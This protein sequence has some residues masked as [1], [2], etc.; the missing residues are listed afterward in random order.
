MIN[1]RYDPSRGMES[2]D[3]AWVS[4][5]NAI[6]RRGRAGRVKHGVCFHLFTS[7]RYHNHLIEQPIPGKNTNWYMYHCHSIFCVYLLTF[8]DDLSVE[9]FLLIWLKFLEKTYRVFTTVK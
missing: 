9:N 1:L 2:L 3:T 4:R 6:Q 8:I 5:A 7:H